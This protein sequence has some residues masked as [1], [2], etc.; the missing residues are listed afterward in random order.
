[1]LNFVIC[2]DKQFVIDKLTKM[3]EKIFVMKD[4]EAK[5]GYTS[6][7]PYDIIDYVEK[8]PTNV[9][10]LDIDLE[11]SL[12][13][14]QLA[15]RIRKKNKSVYIIFITAH[16]EFVFVSFHSKTFDFIQKPVTLE[17]LSQT[18]GLLFEDISGSP[19][20]FI[21]IDKRNKTFIDQ[22]EI[23]F[24][25]KD[26]MKLVFN[27]IDNQYETYNSFS[28]IQ[29]SLP[30]NFVRCHKS[31]IVNINNILDIQSNNMIH[32][33]NHTYCEIG[34][35]YKENLLEVIKN[36]GNHTNNLDSFI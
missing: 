13:G 36:Y 3:L 5:V 21:N 15:N 28:K 1:M 24:I 17:R 31:Y 6:K 26:A 16:S 29:H 30:S 23:T 33:K 10:I 9:L 34:P 32:F 20:S 11:A 7:N 22:N 4:L 2:D 8:N 14:L 27:T 18:I 12:N 35:K 25:K 19:K